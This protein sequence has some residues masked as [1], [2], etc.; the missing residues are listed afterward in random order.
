MN[1]AQLKCYA[2]VCEAD[3]EC[4]SPLVKY[5]EVESSR[6]YGWFDTRHQLRGVRE[7]LAEAA[8]TEHLHTRHEQADP[9][10]T[11]VSGGCGKDMDCWCS[12][13]RRVNE[14]HYFGKS[15]LTAYLTGHVVR[16]GLPR[17]LIYDME[18]QV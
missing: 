13:D 18:K 7:E 6:G 8:I 1:A 10:P 9:N 3:P 16:L 15:K 14:K 12:S 17:Q 5:L 2:A 4:R 11:R